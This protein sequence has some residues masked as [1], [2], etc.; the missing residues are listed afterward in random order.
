MEGCSYL[1]SKACVIKYQ[2]DDL[3]IQ[4]FPIFIYKPDHSVAKCTLNYEN[5]IYVIMEQ[6]TNK[7]LFRLK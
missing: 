3:I 1:N 6:L 5:K 2:F 4:D 7:S